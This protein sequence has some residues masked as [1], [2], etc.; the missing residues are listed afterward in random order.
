[1]LV[2]IHSYYSNRF[3]PGTLFPDTFRIDRSKLMEVKDATILNVYTFERPV[4]LES[5]RNVKSFKPVNVKPPM[6]FGYALLYIMVPSK[7][8]N[9]NES[10]DA[11][12]NT[13]SYAAD[14]FSMDF[15]E[16]FASDE[17]KGNFMYHSVAP[18]VLN[19]V[20]VSTS[21]MLLISS[22]QVTVI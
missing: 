16:A 4:D 10:M 5:N 12:R 3:E 22:H 14:T 11:L 6:D 21:N 1:M 8:F 20:S 2:Q 13:R 17:Y 19:L 7:D 9:L 18:V 15:T